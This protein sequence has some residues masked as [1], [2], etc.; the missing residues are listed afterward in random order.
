MDIQD[1][2]QELRDGV[3]PS[4]D[5]PDLP[6]DFTAEQLIGY[7]PMAELEYRLAKDRKPGLTRAAFMQ[8]WR[9]F[10]IGRIWSRDDGAKDTGFPAFLRRAFGRKDGR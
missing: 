2:R 9:A 7:N 3:T 8:T 4:P 6:N 5:Y 10:R 1:M